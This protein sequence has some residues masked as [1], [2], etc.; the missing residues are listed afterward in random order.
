MHRLKKE[1]KAAIRKNNQLAAAVADAAGIRIN[2]LPPAMHRN[3]M[4]LLTLPVLDVIAAAMNVAD[5]HDLYERVSTDMV[6]S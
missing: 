4:V 5:P 2:S 1:V 3:T 6:E